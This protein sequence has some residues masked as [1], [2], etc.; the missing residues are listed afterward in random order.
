MAGTG[1]PGQ[2]TPDDG[3][4]IVRRFE[5][6]EAAMRE[7]GPSVASSVA[8]IVAGAVTYDAAN[9]GVTG[10][11]VPSG[12]SAEV[13]SATFTVPDGFTT[14]AV[15]AYGTIGAV[16]N[17]GSSSYLYVGVDIDVY[18]GGLHPSDYTANLSWAWVNDSQSSVVTGLTGGDEVVARVRAKG[19]PAWGSSSTFASLCALVIYGR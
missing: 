5:A 6:L 2:V 18:S 4:W 14:A 1:I 8:D 10:Y 7:L 12:T 15:L 19:D 17:S 9:E 13:V 3:D 16:N 11:S